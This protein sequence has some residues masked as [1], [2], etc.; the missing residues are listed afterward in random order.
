MSTVELSKRRAS[1]KLVFTDDV[2]R[3][4]PEWVALG[5]DKREIAAVIGTTVGSL[6]VTCSREGISLSGGAISPKTLREGLS[7]AHRRVLLAAAEQRG[8]PVVQL[9]LRIIETVA[10]DNLVDSVLDDLDE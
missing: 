7:D 2:L 6:E 3:A 8:V 4:I 9:I 1:A 5:A 10:S